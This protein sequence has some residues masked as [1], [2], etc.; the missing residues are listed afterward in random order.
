MDLMDIFIGSIHLTWMRFK[1]SSIDSRQACIHLTNMCFIMS[2]IDSRQAFHSN[3]SVCSELYI[4]KHLHLKPKQIPHVWINQQNKHNVL[5]RNFYFLTVKRTCLKKQRK[6]RFLYY[7][8]V[9]GNKLWCSV[10]LSI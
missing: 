2:S 4:E 5:F 3:H 1:I 6:K 8:I 10:R 7:Q 9:C